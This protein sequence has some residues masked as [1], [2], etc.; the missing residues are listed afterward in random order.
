MSLRHFAVLSMQ[1]LTLKWS[2]VFDENTN[3]GSLTIPRQIH[4]PIYHALYLI[5]SRFFAFSFFEKAILPTL[6]RKDMQFLISMTL[7]A[8]NII[9]RM[10]L[11]DL[12]SCVCVCGGG[13]NDCVYAC[14][15]LLHTPKPG[16]TILEFFSETSIMLNRSSI[17]PY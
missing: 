3:F 8:I 7:P 11:Q 14:F 2:T 12:Y 10:L 17:Q 5:L 4:M 9:V 6:M 15:A 13:S 1:N 16:S